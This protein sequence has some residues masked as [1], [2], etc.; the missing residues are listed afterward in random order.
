[1][2]FDPG[3]VALINTGISVVSQILGGGVDTMKHQ[4]SCGLML[5]S[6]Q[7]ERLNKASMAPLTTQF[8]TSVKRQVNGKSTNGRTWQECV[9][10]RTI[11]PGQVTGPMANPD[12]VD[13]LPN[14][15][16]DRGMIPQ[17]TQ[18]AAS[19]YVVSNPGTA[20]AASSTA[21]PLKAVEKSIAGVASEGGDL[22]SNP[23]VIAGAALL[24]V[25]VV[26]K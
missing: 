1:M 13:Y 12:M 3:T 17:A 10:A 11:F 19:P 7:V 15:A 26:M 21:A 8:R 22:F 6:G 25:V 4:T 5:N 14:V 20:A 9:L 23:L 24:A 2:P 16:D 18:A